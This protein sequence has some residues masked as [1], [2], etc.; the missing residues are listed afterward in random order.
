MLEVSKNRPFFLEIPVETKA[1]FGTA[2]ELRIAGINVIFGRQG[3][4]YDSVCQSNGKLC[5]PNKLHDNTQH[6]LN[7][8]LNMLAEPRTATL[9]Y[10]KSM[11]KLLE[12]DI[13][14]FGGSVAKGLFG[15]IFNARVVHE[16]WRPSAILRVQIPRPELLV[17]LQFAS[18]GNVTL[19]ACTMP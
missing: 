7:I 14:G 2:L 13:P 5:V 10:I 11:N 16:F 1:L 17:F 15:L 12:N 4:S 18:L 19:G 8:P 6:S 9:L 3:E